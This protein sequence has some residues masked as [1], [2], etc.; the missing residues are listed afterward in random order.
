MTFPDGSAADNITVR[1]QADVNGENFV[2][3]DYLSKGG[4]IN[5][6][7]P[8]LPQ[9]AQSVWLEV[10]THIKPWPYKPMTDFRDRRSSFLYFI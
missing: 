9:A 10:S 7:M 6:G 5:F 2:A 3:R 8:A 4:I 1:V